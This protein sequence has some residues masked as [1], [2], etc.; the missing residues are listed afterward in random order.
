MIILHYKRAHGCCQG[1]LVFVVLVCKQKTIRRVARSLSR[2][3]STHYRTQSSR[4]GS[5]YTTRSPHIK[6]LIS[7]YQVLEETW[8][9]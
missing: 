3:E 6:I 2:S 9:T 7:N 1:V 8:L 4:F 5:T